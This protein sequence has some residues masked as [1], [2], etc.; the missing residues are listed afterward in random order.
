MASSD[1]LQGK[2][3]AAQKGLSADRLLPK[4]R[5]HALCRRAR[6]RRRIRAFQ[7]SPGLNKRFRS[8]RFSRL[9][10]ALAG[11]TPEPPE[12]ERCAA[13]LRGLSPAESP[14]F[15]LVEA[16]SIGLSSGAEMGFLRGRPRGR[17]IGAE[18][19]SSKPRLLPKGVVG[20][21]TDGWPGASLVMLSIAAV[22]SS[23]VSFSWRTSGASR[24]RPRGAL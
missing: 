13:T 19:P 7:R 8:Y 20:A 5:A 23:G 18:P 1:P 2:D 3:A 4:R 15:A 14:P 16:A 22:T 21:L 11:A 24:G 9:L 12:G 6:D 17:L 10:D